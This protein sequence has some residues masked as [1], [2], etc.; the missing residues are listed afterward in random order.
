MK[1]ETLDQA[2]ARLTRWRRVRAVLF[3]LRWLR[4]EQP[5]RA[6]NHLK[7]RLWCR[8]RHAPVFVD[9]GGYGGLDDFHRKR[10]MYYGCWCVVCDNRWEENGRT[11]K[12]TKETLA[13]IRLINRGEVSSSEAI[14]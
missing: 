3:R 13:A 9:I 4:R 8:R 1:E 5:R 2:I 12:P 14:N 11:P 10:R 7:G 6:L